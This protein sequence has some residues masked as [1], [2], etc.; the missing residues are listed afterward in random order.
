MREDVR[1][2]AGGELARA[3]FNAADTTTAQVA[4]AQRFFDRLARDGER[5]QYAKGG[6]TTA[7]ATTDPGNG[8]AQRHAGSARARVQRQAATPWAGEALAA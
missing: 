2:L 4:A 1:D 3:E 5:L 6:G 7:E 8:G